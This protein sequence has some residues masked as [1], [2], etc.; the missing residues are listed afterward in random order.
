M[1][2]IF[3]LWLTVRSLV[4]G[5]VVPDQPVQRLQ[6]GMTEPSQFGNMISWK[7]V[8]LEFVKF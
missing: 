5:V 7:I 1:G 6:Q 2:W 8:F 3:S 4:F